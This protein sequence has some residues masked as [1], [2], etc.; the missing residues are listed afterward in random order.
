M[1][2]CNSTK[3]KDCP[4]RNKGGRCPYHSPDCLNPSECE[5][6]IGPPV[7]TKKAKEEKE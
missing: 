4:H 6:R 1:N 7:P 2:F 5:H 3:K